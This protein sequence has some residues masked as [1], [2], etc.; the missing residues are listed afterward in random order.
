M[1]NMALNKVILHVLHLSYVAALQ[2]HGAMSLRQYHERQ[3][4]AARQAQ[5]KKTAVL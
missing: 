1:A 5:K 2:I 4:L 3:T